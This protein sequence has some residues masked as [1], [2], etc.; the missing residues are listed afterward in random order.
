MFFLY[1]VSGATTG[2]SST[3]KAKVRVIDRAIHNCYY[4]PEWTDLDEE[5]PHYEPCYT[6]KDL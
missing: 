4:K 5:E 6:A 1:Q 2:M 3:R